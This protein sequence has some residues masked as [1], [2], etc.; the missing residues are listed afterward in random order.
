MYTVFF[1]NIYKYFLELYESFTQKKDKKPIHKYEKYE[2]Y[3]DEEYLYFN[4]A[5][6]HLMSLNQSKER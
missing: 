4:Q 1:E 5:D 2:E 3:D 6:S